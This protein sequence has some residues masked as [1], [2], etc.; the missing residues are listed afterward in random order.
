MLQKYSA[1]N[2]NEISFFEH[3]SQS[4][5][6]V[7]QIQP[8]WQGLWWQSISAKNMIGKCATSCQL[9]QLLTSSVNFSLMNIAKLS[10]WAIAWLIEML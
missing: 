6:T 4:V 9:G 1:D 10:V 2:Y 5:L 3:F 7:V 8:K